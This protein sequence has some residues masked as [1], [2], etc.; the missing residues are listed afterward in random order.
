MQLIFTVILLSKTQVFLLELVPL[1]GK[2][3]V[4]TH[5]RN[6]GNFSRTLPFILSCSVN[7]LWEFYFA[8]WRSFVFC[9]NNFFCAGS[10]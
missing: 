9:G 7:F 5:P 4:Q 2:G 8:D 1:S 6:S 3:K 10:R